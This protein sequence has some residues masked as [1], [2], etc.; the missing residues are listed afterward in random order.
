MNAQCN[1]AGSPRHRA[2]F[3]AT[4]V[5]IVVTAVGVLARP[6]LPS[7]P[8]Y[9]PPNGLR[10]ARLVAPPKTLI[11]L[12]ER[13]AAVA[14]AC[15]GASR[16]SQHGCG[17]LRVIDAEATRTDERHVTVRLVGEL[18]AAAQRTPIAMR[19]DL[20]AIGSGWTASVVAP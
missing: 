7:A 2:A 13:T 4:A 12:A 18:E 1:V 19:V 10:T 17:R 6:L 5:A 15:G 16:A 20:N 8:R 3:L 14:V 9:Q 11:D